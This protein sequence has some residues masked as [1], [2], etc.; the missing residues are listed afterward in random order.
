MVAG[1]DVPWGRGQGLIDF[2]R[3]IYWSAHWLYNRSVKC[4]KPAEASHFSEV[5]VLLRCWVGSNGRWKWPGSYLAL[6]GVLGHVRL[7]KTRH[8]LITYRRRSFTLAVSS[9]S[10]V[11][12][13][14]Y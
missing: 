2:F 12:V 10:D 7:G 11:F 6:L 4:V 14:Y 13:V 3:V 9:R 5:T 8:D 1:D